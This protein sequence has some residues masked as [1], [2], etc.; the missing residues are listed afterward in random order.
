MAPLLNNFQKPGVYKK[1]KLINGFQKKKLEK[2][3]EDCEANAEISGD[4]IQV[5]DEKSQLGDGQ[6]SDAGVDSIVDSDEEQTSM[7]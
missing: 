4:S 1:V 2:I 7:D 5:S 6:L 3:Q